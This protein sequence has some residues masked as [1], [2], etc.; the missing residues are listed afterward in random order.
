[1]RAS[2]RLCQRAGTGISGQRHQVY[3]TGY[4]GEKLLIRD[5]DP[6]L[7][8]LAVIRTHSRSGYVAASRSGST[9][10]PIKA[11]SFACSFIALHERLSFQ[12]YDA[13]ELTRRIAL[14]E[15]LLQHR[16]VV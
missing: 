9:A 7:Y 6:K 5:I 4:R 3:R 1:M 15:Q 13:D 12:S 10:A 8:D 2:F 16:T 14:Y 11:E